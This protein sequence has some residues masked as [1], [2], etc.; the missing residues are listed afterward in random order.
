M[1]TARSKNDVYIRLTFER[2]EH[3]VRRHPELI[4]CRGWMI[5]TVENPEF[6]MKGDYGE[7]LAVRFFENSPVASKYLVV[8]YKE[9]T[10]FDGYILTAYFTKRYSER[11][12]IVWKK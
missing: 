7:L 6:I 12:K 10:P 1:F 2:W 5:E 9:V 8:A 4:E 3:I 11:R